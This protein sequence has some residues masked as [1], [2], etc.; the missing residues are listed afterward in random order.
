VAASA[1]NQP[2]VVDWQRF[3]SARWDIVY[4]IEKLAAH[5]IRH[6]EAAEAMWNVIEARPNKKSHGPNRYQL[7]ALTNA[8]RTLKLIVP[9]SGTRAMRVITGWPL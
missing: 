1:Y 6:W 7:I 3:D 8:G 2:H 4:D 5:G 9:I